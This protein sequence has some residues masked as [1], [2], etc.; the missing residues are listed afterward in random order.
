MKRIMTSS[1]SLHRTLGQSMYQWPDPAGEPV[2]EGSGQGELDLL[3]LPAQLAA[4]GLYMLEICH[5][6][7]PRLDE[8]YIGE[9]RQALEASGVELFSVLIDAGDITHPDV[10]Q[11]DKEVAWVRDWM[12]IAARCGARCVRVIAGD[13][14][15]N[16]NG[17]W[18]DV[19][20]VQVSAANLRALAGVG[21]E[22]GVE[23]LTENFRALGSRAGALNA[24][25]N[26]CEGE[27]GLCADFGNFEGPDKYDDLAAILPRA[28]SVHAKAD[29]PAVGQMDRED[30]TRCLGLAR[31]AGFA[32]PYSL[33]FSSPGDEWEGVDQT[34][35]VV[36]EWL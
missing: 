15:P 19:E 22:L 10:A 36:E 14:E 6:H 32:G 29:F 9:L 26:L 13:A 24:I 11:R 30:F 7:F 5:F 23:V 34:R 8:G 2:L 1:W 35:E 25:L 16:G 4:H 12:G 31:D 21:R 33:I 28:T 17:D 20:A 27:V 18:R 3:E